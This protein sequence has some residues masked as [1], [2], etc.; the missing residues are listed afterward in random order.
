VDYEYQERRFYSMSGKFKGRTAVV[1]GGGS[2]I[3]AAIVK[4][5]LAEGIDFVAI[6]DYNIE[7]ARKVASDGGAEGKALAIHCDLGKKEDI[8]AAFAE[9]FNN[10][11]RVDLLV[12]NGGMLRDSMLHKMTD[13]MWDDVMA[14]HLSGTYHCTRAVIEKMRANQYGRIVNISSVSKDGNAGQCNYSAAKAGVV[15]FTKSL[16]KESAGK[17][18]TV[19][20]IAPGFIETPILKGV[21]G[22]AEQIMNAPAKRM[23]TPSEVAAL[24][25]F[26]LSPEASYVNGASVNCSGAA[27]I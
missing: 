15:G 4:G 26:L 10:V 27:F 8:R 14:V 3:G 22:V 11:D 7:A 13:E 1:T 21:P 24:A 16:A 2:G 12:N 20:A 5:L 6:L 25:L 18:I 9:I 19:N 23:G 17:N